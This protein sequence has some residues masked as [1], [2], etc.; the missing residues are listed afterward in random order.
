[1][2]ITCVSCGFEGNPKGA[3]F[4]EACG[5]E[6]PATK[7]PPTEIPLPD[8]PIPTPTPPPLSTP[9]FGS[10]KLISKQSNYPYSEFVLDGDNLIIGRFDPDSGPVDI[11]LEGFP[12]ED[13]ISRNHAE[14]YTEGG[15]W[16][17]KDL[18]STNGVFI[19]RQNQTRFSARITTPETL[20]SGDEV[21]I[22]KIRFTFLST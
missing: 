10:A 19:K 12:G 21:A 4:C 9:V 18:G 16:K 20:N 13:T 5:S 3:E 8:I 7:L 11:D 2:F 17:I 15:Y 14:I 1:M 6:L 22:A